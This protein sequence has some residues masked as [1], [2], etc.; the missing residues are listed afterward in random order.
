MS[1][2]D[3]TRTQP[4]VPPRARRVQPARGLWVTG[5]GLLPFSRALCSGPESQTTRAPEK[6]GRPQGVFGHTC[7]HE[8]STLRGAPYL[9]SGSGV[10][11]GQ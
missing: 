7:V 2:R 6:R 1:I 11:G 10:A 5:Y 8:P 3:A 9:C 4:C